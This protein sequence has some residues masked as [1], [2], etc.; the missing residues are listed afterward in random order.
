MDTQTIDKRK[1]TSSSRSGLPLLSI[2]TPA[3]NEEAIITE[4]LQQLCRYL[5]GLE[6]EYRWEIVVVNDG[7]SDNTGPL[8]ENFAKKHSTVRIFHHTVNR[9][10]GGALRTG[11]KQA[12][13]EYVIVLDLDLSYAPEHIGRLLEASKSTEADVVIASPYMKG[14]K[15]TAVP[16]LRVILSRAVNYLMRL[17]APTNIYTFTGMVRLYRRDFLE[18]LNLKSNTYA[19]NPEII[20]KSIILRARIVEIPAHLD[21]S[22]QNKA[23]ARTSNVRIFKGILSGLMSS[24]IFRPYALF[25]VIGLILAIMSAWTIGWIFIHTAE[26]YSA[27][28]VD[29]GLANDRFTEAVGLVFRQR[30]HAFV[31]G[32]ITLIVSLQFLS[33]GFLSLQNKRYF[34]ELFHL[35]TSNLKLRN[36]N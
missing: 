5:E 14:G 35:G 10:L 23:V 15:S 13:G 9:N 7:S 12:K 6:N 21:W 29:S 1:H 30:P 17:T 22:F 19:I 32:A 34:D 31:V 27:V 25:M 18:S 16:F 33:M 3:Y 24:F 4:N 20:H 26:A 28:E 2:I 36:D 11:F 8:A